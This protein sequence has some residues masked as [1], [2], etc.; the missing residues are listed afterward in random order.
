VWTVCAQF[1]CQLLFFPG[2]QLILT[3]TFFLFL[4]FFIDSFILHIVQFRHLRV[5]VL[6]VLANLWF[7]AT[8]LRGL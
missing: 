6:N 7:Y 3:Q 5:F 1:V 2:S 8:L 4:H